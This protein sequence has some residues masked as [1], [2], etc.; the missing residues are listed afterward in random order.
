MNLG[1]IVELSGFN[2]ST[3]AKV[4]GAIGIVVDWT[5]NLD[6][7]IK[8]CKPARKFDIIPTLTAIGSGVGIFGVDV[9]SEEGSTG[10]EESKPL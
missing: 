7:S 2:F 3:I 6:R 8:H 5:C 4:G 9:N 10:K 1:D